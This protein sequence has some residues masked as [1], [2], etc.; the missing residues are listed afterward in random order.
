MGGRE[1]SGTRGGRG[2]R[3]HDRHF[4]RYLKTLYA[5]LTEQ[6]LGPDR[7]AWAFDPLAAHSEAAWA[8]R[9]PAALHFLAAGWWTNYTKRQQ[10]AAQ[11]QQQQA[12][13]KAAQKQQASGQEQQQEQQAAGAVA[14]AVLTWP[15]QLQADAEGQMLFF[16]RSLSPTLSKLPP[17]TGIRVTLGLNG[18]QLP[19]QLSLQPLSVLTQ[20]HIEP[21]GEL[22]REVF[23]K[24]GLEP[25]LHQ[26]LTA[27]L[28][29]QA[30][31]A[32]TG[33]AAGGQ[34]ASSDSDEWHVLMLP[35]TIK[36]CF[37]LDMAFCGE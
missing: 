22:Q 23:E 1:Y 8:E 19:T 29:Q 26:V 14:G 13:H 18:W 20:H 5:A 36:E 25:G 17:G 6:G 7:L 34:P 21:P 2:R 28:R 27:R 31:A 35:P 9:L 4:P 37:Q 12:A 3:E 30:A 16:N 15:P 32:T 10:Q 33:G 24:W 11:Q